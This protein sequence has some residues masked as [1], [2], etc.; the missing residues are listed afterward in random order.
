MKIIQ[1][2]KTDITE[3]V[4]R[5][6]DRIAA[7]CIK[8]GKTE[9]AMQAA[10]VSAEIS[11]TWNQ[12]YSDPSLEK[13]LLEITESMGTRELPRP[14]SDPETVLFYDGFA[15]DTRG[16]ALIYLKA[17]CRLGYK[18]IYVTYDADYSGKNAT[19]QPE[20]KKATRGSDIRMIYIRRS[21][22]Y[23]EKAKEILNLIDKYRPAVSFLYSLPFD[24]PAVCAFTK[25]EGTTRRFLINLTDN[26]FWAGL[27]SFDY[28]IE[29]R[30]YGAGISFYDRRIP[31][32]KLKVLPF[33]PFTDEGIE[34]QGYPFSFDEHSQKL[35]FSGGALYKTFSEDNA[36]YKL[37]DFILA[38]D[39]E[40]V[41]W[42]AG[43][44]D[45]SRF[46]PLLRKYA[47]RIFI[48]PER[49]DLLQV[50]KRCCF[51]LSTYPVS[52]G[53]MFQYAAKAG[54]IPLTFRHDM[55]NEGFLIGQE[56]LGIEFDSIEETEAEISRCLSDKEY[57]EQKEKKLTDAL[58][59]EEEFTE[60]L[61]KLLKSGKNDYSVTIKRQ[62]TEIFR[63]EYAKRW[64]VNSLVPFLVRRKNKWI[65]VKFP[66]FM[67]LY[68]LRRIGGK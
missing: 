9:R 20:I 44:G 11:Y 61:G 60:Q 41:F 3:R 56:E 2:N 37:V 32:G 65:T 27:N 54:I 46:D 67:L 49:K 24:I 22:G 47:G 18:V 43:S 52:G 15:L 17:L 57:R 29:F 53:L 51:Y 19:E 38:A 34:F 58:V 23:L 55:C 42:Y 13:V 45:R 62:E 40:T 63:E 14:R 21:S 10:G 59:T 33:Y 8:A 64:E 7:D 50:L 28:C 6:L 26:A 31:S 48:T 25:A 30:D 35:V 4:I 68:I 16:L 66:E 5:K 12:Y 39:P 36:Y 1:N